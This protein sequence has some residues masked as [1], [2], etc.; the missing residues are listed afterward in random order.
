M[1]HICFLYQRQNIKINAL[2][3]RF[4]QMKHVSNKNTLV[5][6]MSTRYERK[7]SLFQ[8]QLNPGN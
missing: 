5:K 6:K 3:L 4:G 7:I 2:Y 1:A 8:T